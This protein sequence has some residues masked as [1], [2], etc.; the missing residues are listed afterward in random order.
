[1]TKAVV[2]AAGR[3][4]RLGFLTRFRPKALMPV[5]GR[6]LVAHVLDSLARAGIDEAVVVCGYRGDQLEGALAEGTPLGVA[7]VRNPEYERE[8][9]L[10][11]AAAREAC[12]NEPFLLVMGDHLFEPALVRRLLR[13]GESFS[14][15]YVDRAPSLVAADFGSWPADYVEEATK[16]EVDDAGRVGAIG[17]GL[18]RWDALD[19]GVFLCRPPVWEAVEAAGDA[20]LSAVF[21][22][23][24]EEG[25]LVAADV[26]GCFWYDVDTADDLAA[27]EAELEEAP[28]VAKRWP[29]RWP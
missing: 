29:Q 20:P 7:C 25:Q 26:T 8:A 18:S 28:R 24:A 5:A 12:G 16:L 10:S 21:G 9:S 13:A 17:K 14:S 19:T 23:L 3:G 1:M 22:R 6:A 15:M 4:S 27:V 11:L 2:L